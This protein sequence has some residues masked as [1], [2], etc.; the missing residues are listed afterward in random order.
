MAKKDLSGKK[1]AILVDEGF[2]QVELIKPR[3]ALDQIGAQTKIISPQDGEVRMPKGKTSLLENEVALIS[4]WIEQGAE[5]DTPADAKRHYD[6]QHPPVYSRPPVITS[7]EAAALAS[8]AGG[9]RGRLV[10]SG[11]KAIRRVCTAS[12]PISVQV[13]KKWCA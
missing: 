2:E 8:T 10:T 5:D 9:R 6:A 12:A 3:K 7:S 4:S 13:S 11:K 1:I